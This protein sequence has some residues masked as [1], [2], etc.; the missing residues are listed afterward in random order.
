MKL[1]AFSTLTFDCY[2]TLIDWETG[3][4]TALRP[5]LTAG[6]RQLSDDAALEAFGVAEARCEAATPAKPYPDILTDTFR[7]LAAQ[8]DLPATDEAALAFGA[9]VGDWPA[10]PDSPA[11][12]HYLKRHYRL[13]IL[14]NVDR[15][16]FARSNERL[17]VDFDHIFTA[18]DI[19]SYKP[20]RRNFEHMLRALAAAGIDQHQILHTAQ[21]LYHDI[22]PAR[23][24]GLA[25]LWVNRREAKHGGGATPPADAQP[26]AEVASLAEL[27]ALHQAEQRGASV[28]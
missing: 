16:S 2:G 20:D 17:Q 15:A 27:V 1:T 21:S 11:A 3:I 14:S 26:D 23:A 24:L 4:L 28:R 25:T 6:G 12:L 5:W 22:A 10:F 9:S 18:Q 8:W 13:V 19:G 7:A